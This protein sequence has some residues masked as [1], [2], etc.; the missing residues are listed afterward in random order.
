M[1]QNEQ[2]KLRSQLL[3]CFISWSACRL[4][5]A[6][7]F[8]KKPTRKSN[9]IFIYFKLDRRLVL[10]EVM[11]CAVIIRVDIEGTSI[12]RSGTKSG[13]WRRISTRKTC[14]LE[15]QAETTWTLLSI[16]TRKN[17]SEEIRDISETGV[18]MGAMIEKKEITLQTINK[19]NINNINYK[20]S[21]MH[22][23]QVFRTKI[24]IYLLKQT[25]TNEI[26]QCLMWSVFFTFV[27]TTIILFYFNILYCCYVPFA[28]HFVW[29]SVIQEVKFIMAHCTHFQPH[30][31]SQH[32]L[33]YCL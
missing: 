23:T 15:R 25:M 10:Q 5:Q 27:L 30:W 7:L 22:G 26:V 1:S 32:F 21:D 18:W 14:C 8:T 12:I 29:D 4:L 20:N 16:M 19:I 3:K 17:E 6:N 24:W 11:R 13:S 2:I 33:L 31:R 28:K 9:F